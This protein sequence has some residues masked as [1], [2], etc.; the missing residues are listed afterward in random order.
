MSSDLA[1]FLFGC[2]VTLFVGA[3]VSLLVW[4]AAKEKDLE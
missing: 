4:G 2:V 3:A 1:I